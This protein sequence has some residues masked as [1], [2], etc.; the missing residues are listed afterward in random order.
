MKEQL[1]ESIFLS[2]A[3]IA[4]T[5][6]GI[7]TQQPTTPPLPQKKEIKADSIIRDIHYKTRKIDSL[8]A[9]Y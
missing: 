4:L 3:A 8:L 6:A 5:V 7:S 2:C 1:I 9:K